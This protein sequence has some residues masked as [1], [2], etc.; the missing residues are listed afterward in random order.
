MATTISALRDLSEEVRIEHLRRMLAKITSHKERESTRAVHLETCLGHLATA[1]SILMTIQFAL[2][3]AQTAV[4]ADVDK[5][6][7][8]VLAL[9]ASTNSF[10]IAC[11]S[12]HAS[13]KSKLLENCTEKRRRWDRAEDTFTMHLGISLQDG[14]LTSDEYQKLNEIYADV[15]DFVDG[16][17]KKDSTEIKNFPAIVGDLP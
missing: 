4:F 5:T 7:I 1:L 9:I 15:S 3:V 8:G 13:M 14:E 11:L 2:N 10:I 12:R 17:V 6:L 16:S